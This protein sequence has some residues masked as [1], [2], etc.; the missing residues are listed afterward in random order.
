MQLQ[1]NYAKPLFIFLITIMWLNQLQ[2]GIEYYRQYLKLI[3]IKHARQVYINLG[4]SNNWRFTF[5][6]IYD[7]FA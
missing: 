2:G 1:I 5:K 7:T 3:S 4:Q 6:R